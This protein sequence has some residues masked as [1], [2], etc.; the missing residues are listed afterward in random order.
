MKYVYF[1]CHSHLSDATINAYNTKN[2]GFFSSR[3]KAEEIVEQYK[4]ILGFK[5]YPDCFKIEKIELNYD[6]YEFQEGD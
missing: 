3:K 5:D 1:V 2:I 4:H 6:D